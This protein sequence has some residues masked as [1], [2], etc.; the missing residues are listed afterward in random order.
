[1]RKLR[2]EFLQGWKEGWQLYWSPLVGFFE[3]A[4]KVILGAFK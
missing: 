1:M 4:K 3:A 2:D